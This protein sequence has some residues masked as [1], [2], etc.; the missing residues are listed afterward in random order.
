MKG[1]KSLFQKRG[2]A[3]EHRHFWQR[4]NAV[5][6][7]E[8]TVAVTNV[9]SE[10]TP[11]IQNPPPEA[12]VTEANVLTQ[13]A[14]FLETPP[15]EE[16]VANPPPERPVEENSGSQSG[17]KHRKSK[18]NLFGRKR[19]HNVNV[20]VSEQATQTDAPNTPRERDVGGPLSSNPA[21]Q[22]PEQASVQPLEKIP[23]ANRTITFADETLSRKASSKST[24]SQESRHSEKSTKSADTIRRLDPAQQQPPPEPSP[25]ESLVC[26]SDY[27]R[28]LTFDSDATETTFTDGKGTEYRQPGSVSRQ[29]P[30]PALQIGPSTGILAAPAGA[31]TILVTG[32]S[33]N[34]SFGHFTPLSKPSS[35]DDST[36]HSTS[37]SRRSRSRDGSSEGL[38]EPIDEAIETPNI[39]AMLKG[40]W[41]VRDPPGENPQ[42]EIQVSELPGGSR[43]SSEDGLDP[44]S[45]IQKF[46]RKAAQH[47][48]NVSISLPPDG[49]QS[50]PG[51]PLEPTPATQRRQKRGFR[52]V[53]SSLEI[54]NPEPNQIARKQAVRQIKSLATLCPRLEHGTKPMTILA[55]RP[56][57]ELARLGGRSRLEDI[58][59]GPAPMH[60]PACIA[61]AIGILHKFGSIER[62]GHGRVFEKC[63]RKRAAYRIYNQWADPIIEADLLQN[64]VNLTV[65]DIQMPQFGEDKPPQAESVAWALKYVLVGLP[66][67]VLGSQRLYY[68]LRDLANALPA[69]EFQAQ[70]IAFAVIGCALSEMELDLILAVFGLLHFLLPEV[71]PEAQPNE[72]SGKEPRA[73][74]AAAIAPILLG[75][76]SSGNTEVNQ[77][78]DETRVA[79]FLL[80]NWHYFILEVRFWLKK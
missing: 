68:A 73:K 40:K 79:R 51:P 43:T 58:E 70:L 46:N 75:Q 78:D 77:R 16:T 57:E 6:P 52:R 21:K 9:S 4:R 34:S 61:E 65:R 54:G 27:L 67:G 1:L 59:L 39:S 8:A 60:L 11:I 19:S 48:I 31:P 2:A 30:S 12:I 55:G 71:S 24:Y 23:S 18:L 7:P 49:E 36:A 3:D 45:A 20:G 33:E 63:A 10:I 80:Q 29:G 53:K 22:T 17:A 32:S 41:V 15:P 62:V 56:V 13:I 74:V 38:M 28:A 47:D 26:S 37:P 64:R 25:R 44:P 35:A 69:P 42:T 5:K 72:Q 76:A 14:P 50:A 66:Y